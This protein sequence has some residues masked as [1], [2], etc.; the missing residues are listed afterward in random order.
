MR[1]NM[2]KWGPVLAGVM[3][4]FAGLRARADL[5]VDVRTQL[6]QNSFSAAAA[7]LNAYKTQ[8]GVTQNIWKLCRGWR[9]EPPP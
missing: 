6:A 8:H 2:G 9:A 1:V 3:L 4:A 7:E 5:V